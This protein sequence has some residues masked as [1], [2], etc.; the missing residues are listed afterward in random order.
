[1]QTESLRT[2]LHTEL[3]SLERSKKDW[4]NL[5]ARCQGTPFQS[6]E[7][8]IQWIESFA[9]PELKVVEVRRAGELVGIA[10]LCCFEREPRSR[11]VIAGAYT[12]DYLDWL[13]DPRFST[14][15]VS[16]V[17]A[18]LEQCEATGRLLDLTDL[19]SRSE[20]LRVA[21]S[22]GKCGGI[23]VSSVCQIIT[24]PEN[25]LDG[26]SVIP[27]RQS[28]NLRTAQNRAA[29]LGDV[30]VVAASAPE[31]E[32]FIEAL[33]RLHQMR[34]SRQGMA[35]V[36]ASESVKHFHR[37]VAPALFKRKMLD[38]YAIRLG[39]SLIGVLYSLYSHGIAYAYLQ[40]FDPAFVRISPGARLLGHFIDQSVRSGHR[41]IDLLRG[42][43]P[44][45]YRWG[46][47]D[48]NTYRLRMR[49]R[50]GSSNT[51]PAEL[52]A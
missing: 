20:L 42:Q 5:W 40:G 28:R 44:Y 19:P 26:G 37:R 27:A 10:P 9:P 22:T 33:F 30:V 46:A 41:A 35:G 25:A 45:K 49:L 43:E 32:E 48:Q 47:T 1:M 50:G 13:V 8:L 16:A 29:E 38:L 14:E 7:W 24:I 17:V 12:S 52:A 18:E 2:R 3:H 51:I 23:D 34:W 39:D 4:Q 11:L 21:S 36:L 6:P 31:F 15:V